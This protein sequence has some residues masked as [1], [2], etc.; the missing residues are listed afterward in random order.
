[1]FAGP[2]GDAIERKDNLHQPPPPNHQ[3]HIPK[4]APDLSAEQEADLY[5]D[6]SEEEPNVVPHRREPDFS[7]IARDPSSLTAQ[8]HKH[9]HQ[10]PPGSDRLD[11][12][13][14]DPLPQPQFQVSSFINCLRIVWVS[15][16][17]M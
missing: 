12:I 6:L 16:Q 11:D 4:P 2:Y 13:K 17:Q 10:S 14:G 15:G 5:D 8:T 1:M 9:V 7:S 3:P